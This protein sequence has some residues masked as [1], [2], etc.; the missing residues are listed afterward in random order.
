MNINA[1][2]ILVIYGVYLIKLRAH[3]EYEYWKCRSALSKSLIKKYVYAGKQLKALAGGGLTI[4]RLRKEKDDILSS[5]AQR[6][7]HDNIMDLMR[8][9]NYVLNIR[10]KYYNKILES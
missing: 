3:F 2:E 1:D 8:T 7:I 4:Q 5:K 9:C 6:Y 10:T